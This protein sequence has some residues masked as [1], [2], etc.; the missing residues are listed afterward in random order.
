MVIGAVWAGPRQQRHNLGTGR[1]G[2][3]GFVASNPVIIAVF[4]RAGP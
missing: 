4:V 1:M 2:D 3:P